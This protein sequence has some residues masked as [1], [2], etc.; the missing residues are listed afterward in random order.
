MVGIVIVSHSKKLAEGVRELAAQMVRGT[1]ALAVAAGIDD[2]ENP[3]GTDAIQVQQAIESV[4]SEDG[5]LVL[6]DLGSALMSAEM[7]LEFL[8]EAHRQ[9]VYLCAAPLVEGTVAAVVA[10]ATGS[11]I[12]QVMAEAQGALRAKAMQLG[13]ADNSCG[14]DILSTPESASE[15]ASELAPELASEL[16]PELASELTGA[17]KMP[18]PQDEQQTHEIRLTV[19][20]RLG[21]HARPAAQF[22]ATAAQFQS[23]IKV[24]NIT[25]NTVFVRADSINQVATLGAR[26][27]HELVITAAGTDA[28]AALAAL[29]ALVAANF[30]EDDVT[31]PSVSPLFV[32]EKLSTG[33]TQGEIVGIAASSGIAIAPAIIYRPTPLQLLRNHVMDADCEWEGLQTA[34]QTAREEIE[35]LLS[36]TS[37]KIGDA[38]AAIFDAH[39]LCLEDPVLKSALRDRIFK[40]HQNAEVAW[41]GAIDELVQAYRQLDDSYLQERVADVLDVGQRVLRLLVGTAADAL[42]LSS[43]AILVA[44]DLSPSHTA[45][46]DPTKVL[47]ICT[48]SGSATSHSAILART[49]GIPAVVGVSEEVLHITD[50][51]LL[52]LD[53]ETGQLWIEPVTNTLALLEAKREAW[54][55]SQQQ[56]RAAANQLS[57]TGDGARV[58]VLANIAGIN[59]AVAALELGAEGVGLLRTEFLYLER[60]TP[61]TEEEQLAVYREIAQVMGNRPIVIRTLDVGGDKPLPYLN[62]PPETNPFLGCRGIRF[63]LDCPDLFKT[64]LRAILRASIGHQIKLMFPMISTLGEVRAAKE[65]LFQVQ[66]QLRQADI[67]FDENMAVGIMIEVPS[68]VAIADQLAAEVDFFSIGTNDLSQ[69]VMA[70]DRTNP[71]VASLADAFHPAVLRMVQQTVEA[72]RKAGISVSLCGELASNPQAAPILIGLGLNVLSLNPQAIPT[73]KQVIS[74]LTIAQTEAIASGA[75]QQDS[76][77]KVRE[78][79]C[80]SLW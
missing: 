26:Q 38:E 71:R 77:A 12:E 31:S 20:N 76:A 3:L 5:V 33:H 19:S 80:T 69:Y 34:M 4:Y 32:G 62:L 75:L 66:E 63:C 24:Q 16:A 47:G 39:L 73:I 52:G 40:R 58:T 51:T 48:T 28:D 56:A 42:N 60:T 70:G 65:M 78:I 72:G 64:Q 49:L 35:V 29:Q 30:A 45:Q 36:Q 18:T 25:R 59:D 37:I 23:H 6:M 55:A 61:P 44:H 22:V 21:L 79:T 11:N 68:S 10:A 7:A 74:Q 54:Q 15:L 8:G 14:V 9:K 53:G 50:G 2:P 46:L 43:P 27:G 13:V 17:G 41:Q 1:V 57:M 67:P